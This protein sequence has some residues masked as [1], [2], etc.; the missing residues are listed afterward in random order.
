MLNDEQL[1]RHL[2]DE[3]HDGIYIVDKDKNITYWNKSAE[4]LT[5][6]KATDTIGSHCSGDI[7][8]HC[9]KGGAT[10]CKKFCPVNE[11]ITNGKRFE[12]EVYLQH[13]EGH[14][15][16]VLMCISPLIDKEG[17]ITGAVEIFSDHSWSVAAVDRIEELRKIA[18]LDALTE[19]ANRRFIEISISNLLSGM[20]RYN[21]PFG[22]LFVDVDHFK[23]I[24]D[25]YGHEIGDRILKIIAKSLS[26][27]L[28]PLDVIGRWGG[29]EFVVLLLHATH[30]NLTAVATRLRLLVENSF[31]N[32]ENGVIRTT[33]SIGGTVATADDTIETVIKR[34]DELMYQSKQKGRNCVTI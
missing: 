5:G 2:L 30:E 18:L 12:A 14:R 32:T 11:S 13:R 28:R 1:Y 21:F 4:R 24:N 20:K 3:M 6:Y 22:L 33:V 31:L 9:D 15:V 25:T 34:A 23:K 29:E 27:T 26:S 16:P 17:K 8:M 10:L 7:L 19:V